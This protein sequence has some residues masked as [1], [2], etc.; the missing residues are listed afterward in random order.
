LL[1]HSV[2]TTALGEYLTHRREAHVEELRRLVAFETV[3]GQ[4]GHEPQMAECAG[5]LT[6]HLQRSGFTAGVIE[7]PEH[8]V[9]LAERLDAGPDAPT[10]LVYGHYDV[11]PVE[12]LDL[13][14]S[15]PFALTERDGT[16]YGRGVADMKGNL[17]IYLQSLR[18]LHEV[19]GSVG[20]NLRVLL[21]GNEESNPYALM[22]VAEHHRDS[23][24]ADA[25]VIADGSLAGPDDPS[26]TI[27]VRGMAALRVSVRTADHDLHSGG[28]GGAIPNA[29][30][31]LVALLATLHDAD[32]RVIVDG[33]HDD[34][35]DMPAS[36]GVD[37]DTLL[38]ETGAT[39]LN[40]DPDYPP[41]E[42]IRS[43][44][45]I[46]I[47]G[48][49]AGY[50]GDGLKTIVVASAEAVLSC[51]L[52]PDQDADAVIELL[53]AHLRS[54]AP[55]G[56]TVD[57]PWTLPGAW[58]AR[59]DADAPAARAALAALSEVWGQE[60]RP[61]IAGGSLP[62]AAILS[63]TTGAP[64]VNVAFSLPTSGAHAPDEHLPEELF[65]RGHDVVCRMLLGLGSEARARA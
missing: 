23:L 31:A 47:V 15:P 14:S 21:E 46:E 48:I 16:L 11:Q 18:A 29:A 45:T 52:V 55:R 13:W 20:C 30:T 64:F 1:D 36:R 61:V 4:P 50:T 63:R 28:Y 62:A 24:S 26:V 17:L 42:R 8:P 3:G 10:V 65:H 60:A 6:E 32:G 40:G 9:V 5:W 34:V 56:A 37:R 35:R 27:G 43:R 25:V 7:T 51:R 57:I 33:F 59:S 49:D 44:P 19:T 53:S 2:P 39:D 54:H 38:K 22:W 58:P 12:P 41:G